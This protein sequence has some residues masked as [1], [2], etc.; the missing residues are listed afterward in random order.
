MSGDAG[1]G[2]TT[3]TL[4]IGNRNYSSWSLRAWLFLA[5]HGVPFET[6]RLP[7]D[8]AEF[9]RRIGAYSPSRRV[10]VLVDGP[11]RV[12]DSLAI[13]E[14]AA[15]R[16]PGVRAWP[17]DPDARSFA[18]SIS[19]EMHSGFAALRAELPFNCRASGRRIAPGPASQTD[20]ERV[21]TIW[22][23]AR[24]RHGQGGP[25]LCGA[26]GIADA[27]YAPVALRFL[28]YGS[29]GAAPAAEWVQTLTDDPPVQ[30]GLAAA[31]AE[32]EVIAAEERG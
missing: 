26:F 17:D 29:P 22:D 13:C 32:P 8:T 19:C 25:W 16:W 20:I 12:W 7:L 15:E 31:A 27:M 4:V 23:E 9:R 3:P 30:R 24:R 21:L 5:H 2:G 14:Y 6:L 11:R 1:A 28:T 10:P 18:R